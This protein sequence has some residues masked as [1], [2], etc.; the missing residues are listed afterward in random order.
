MFCDPFVTRLDHAQ[1]AQ[2]R[3][4]FGQSHAIESDLFPPHA[5][6]FRPRKPYIRSCRHFPDALD[7][8]RTGQFPARA[9]LPNTTFA[10][11]ALPSN[12]LNCHPFAHFRQA[13]IRSTSRPRYSEQSQLS[14]R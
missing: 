12:F 3:V 7:F 10:Y 9:L 4:S 8:P 6:Q 2:R 11:A 1:F 14:A 13:K 5:R